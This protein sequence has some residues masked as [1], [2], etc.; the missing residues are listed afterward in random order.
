MRLV[1]GGR[2]VV[3]RTKGR[4]DSCRL[5]AVCHP[6][7]TVVNVKK[8]CNFALLAATSHTRIFALLRLPSR[9]GDVNL[10]HGG[11]FL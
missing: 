9:Y 10:Y 11:V 4:S 8:Q 6:H 3:T 7:P 1:P 2:G 5:S